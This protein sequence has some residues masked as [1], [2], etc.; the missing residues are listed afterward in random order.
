M[1]SIRAPP[2]G[3][4]LLRGSTSVTFTRFQSA[5]PRRGATQQDGNKTTS[6]KF[7]SARP[8]R[9]ATQV[10]VY[11]VP[12]VTS[13]NPRAPEGARHHPPPPDRPQALVSIR[14]PPKGRDGQRRQGE[15]P[16][17]VSIRAPPKGRDMLPSVVKTWLPCFNPR[18]PEGA[19]HPSFST[20]LA[21]SLFQ[22]AR[23]RRGATSSPQ[24]RRHNA[25]VSIRAPPKGRDPGAS[26]G[27]SSYPCFNPRAPEGARPLP[28]YLSSPDYQVSIR[29]PPK[30]R[31]A[32]TC[33]SIARISMFQSAR[34]RRGATQ[35]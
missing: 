2:K 1:V 21:M 27:V 29:A 15:N 4:D 30:G 25:G 35:A 17:L 34:P 32:R 14:A 20:M 11:L 7:Q 12:L 5:R 31:D 8:R 28:R 18:A 9:G 33:F 24:C 26:F 13:F 19:R 6:T 23:P 3:R 16:G 10:H 22:S